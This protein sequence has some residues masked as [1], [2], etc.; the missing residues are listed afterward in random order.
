MIGECR[1]KLGFGELSERFN[2]E[3]RVC[4][5]LS[6]SPSTSHLHA[7]LHLVIQMSLVET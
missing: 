1:I 6:P 2:P 3:S 5:P 4:P 7:I